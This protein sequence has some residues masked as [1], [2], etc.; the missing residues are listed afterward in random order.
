MPS[1]VESNMGSETAQS[2]VT[3]EMRNIH[4]SFAQLRKDVMDL[5]SHAFGLGRTGADA[6][7]EG[8]AEAVESLKERLSELKERGAEGVSVVEQRIE[9]NPIRAV[10]MAF[11]IGFILAKVFSRK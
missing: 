9:E 10:L 7:K 1:D 6:A 8:A 4:E 3:D 5:L 11:G 2:E